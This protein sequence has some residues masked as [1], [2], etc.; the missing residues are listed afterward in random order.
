VGFT[1][2]HRLRQLYDTSIG[3]ALEPLENRIEEDVHAF[4]LEAVI[5]DFV[6]YM[7]VSLPL[8]GTYQPKNAALSVTALEV[9]RAKGWK[10][11]DTDITNGLGRVYWPG[12]FEVL[13]RRPVFIL[14]GAHN[15]HGIE[16][17]ADSLSRH[18]GDAHRSGDAAVSA[19]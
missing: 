9:L 13:M 7:N 15:P 19:G 5:F 3:F 2:A 11:S 10:I 17:T 4:G 16:A 18:F 8:V 14:D 12:R 1:A 6:P